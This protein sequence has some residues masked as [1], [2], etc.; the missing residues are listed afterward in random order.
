MVFVFGQFGQESARKRPLTRSSASDDNP[1][2]DMEDDP[3]A[4][5][6]YRSAHGDREEPC[7][8]ARFN[9]TTGRCRRFSWKLTT[10]SNRWPD[11]PAMSVWGLAQGAPRGQRSR[12]SILGLRLAG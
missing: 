5:S 11:F 10:I 7:Y 12:G 4:N 9:L 8:A 6:A 3:D 1:F 2:F